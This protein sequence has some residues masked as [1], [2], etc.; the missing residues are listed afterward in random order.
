M[1]TL[2]QIGVARVFCKVVVFDSA[3]GLQKFVVE[4]AID[5]RGRSC[6]DSKFLYPFRTFHASIDLSPMTLEGAHAD[7]QAGGDGGK[8]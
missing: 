6:M 2:H 8:S 7:C 4:D 5:V 3:K 1:Q